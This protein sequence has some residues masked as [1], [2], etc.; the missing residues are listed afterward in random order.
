M[1]KMP[2]HHQHVVVALREGGTPSAAIVADCIARLVV[3]DV[4]A[5]DPDLE[6]QRLERLYGPDEEVDIEAMREE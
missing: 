6:A 3:F 4:G 5:V 1:R 2:V